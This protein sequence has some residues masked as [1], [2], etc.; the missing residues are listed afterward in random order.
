MVSSTPGYT[1]AVIL[2]P[3]GI[4][5]VCSGDQL[6]LTCTLTDPGSRVLEW[7]FTPTTF[8]L[9]LPTRA[10][11]AASPSDQT[12]Q[13]MVNSTWFTTSRISAEDQSP[14]VSRLVTN[15]VTISLN[16]T[17]VNCND[18]LMMETS[19]AILSVISKYSGYVGHNQF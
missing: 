6:E 12:T 8:S 10:I 17:V 16:G 1:G 9:S 7:H 2:S 14:L 3:S 13:F 19:S 5:S 18:V 4:A 11:E 15:P